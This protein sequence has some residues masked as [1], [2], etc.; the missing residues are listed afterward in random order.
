MTKQQ[1]SQLIL[2]SLGVSALLIMLIGTPEG[3]N[4]APVIT[5]KAKPQSQEVHHHRSPASVPPSQ[6]Q[7]PTPNAA[8]KQP[9]WKNQLEQTLFT[10]SS[11]NLKKAE[12]EKVDSF[13]WKIGKAHIKVDS[14]IVKLEH[15][16]G[17]KTSFRAIVDASNGKI[18]QT[19][20]QPVV[21]EIGGKASDIRIDSR[22]H[23][24]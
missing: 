19:W 18:L 5:V 24:E 8:I 6:V 21:D 23:H 7:V 4:P 20:D 1:R 11:G 16:Q 14:I 17:Q 22:Y 12:I 2:S 15:I 13:D 10:Q 3:Q 9:H